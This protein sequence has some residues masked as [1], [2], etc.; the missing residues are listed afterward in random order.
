[1]YDTSAPML[2]LIRW[3]KQQVSSQAWA[4]DETDPNDI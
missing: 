1:M 4:M 3:Q 2:V